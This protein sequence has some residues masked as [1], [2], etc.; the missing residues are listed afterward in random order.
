MPQRLNLTGPL[1]PRDGWDAADCTM[2]ASLDVLAN[3]ST[4]LLIREALYGAERFDEFVRRTGFSEPSVA[5]RLKELVQHEILERHDYKEPGQ[6]TRQNYALTAKGSQLL[7]ILTALMRWG[8]RWTTD[9]GGPVE[10]RHHDCGAPIEV[11]LRC[12]DGH[13]VDHPA[14]IDVALRSR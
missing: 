8:D 1:A 12:T 13:L 14:D 4:F 5:A 3:R 11:E 10:F 2:A 9:G 7:P 6:R